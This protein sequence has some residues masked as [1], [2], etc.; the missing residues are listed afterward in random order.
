MNTWKH[1]SPKD[2]DWSLFGDKNGR[3]TSMVKTFFEGNQF[4]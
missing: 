3:E 2:Y 1:I 4:I